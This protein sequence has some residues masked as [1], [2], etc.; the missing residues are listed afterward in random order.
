L[1]GSSAARMGS[2]VTTCNFPLNLPTSTLMTVPTGKPVIVGLGRSPRRTHLRS[3]RQTHLR[4][5]DH[6]QI[7]SS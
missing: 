2:M 3:R 7:P 6:H 5:G 1:G 4:S